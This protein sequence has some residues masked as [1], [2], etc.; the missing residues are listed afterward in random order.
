MEQLIATF[1]D[2][3]RENH[4]MITREDLVKYAEENEL[5]ETM[6]EIWMKLFD[7]EKTGKITIGSFCDRLGI[8]LS[9]EL[10]HVKPDWNTKAE[11]PIRMTKSNVEVIHAEMPEIM[12]AQLVKLAEQ[13]L[14]PDLIEGDGQ[15]SN[16]STLFKSKL[17]ELYG[18]F[19]QVGV[20]SGPYWMTHS[21][22]S[23]RSFQFRIGDYS[24]LAWQ[25]PVHYALRKC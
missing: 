24:I 6:P 19:W 17:D 25:T 2:I 12:Q 3:G 9:P 23:A 11:P 8:V 18:P 20:L 1:C 10:L 7:P 21:H 4:F 22:R 13:Y 15:M 16:K 14:V 5:Q